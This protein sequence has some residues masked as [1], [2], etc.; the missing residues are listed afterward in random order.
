MYF[1]ER[2]GA[3]QLIRTTYDKDKKRPK[4][5]ILG[6]M[7]RRKLAVPDDVAAQL[8]PE[9][10]IELTSYVE[11]M[12]SLDVMRRKLEAHSLL[13][14]VTTAIEYARDLEDDAERD[15][16]RQEFAQA[17]IALRRASAAALKSSDDT[18]GEAEE[19]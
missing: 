14:T 13:R 6:R 17:I 18:A 15:L 11:R 5:E 16:L 10:K 19:S 4:Q 3:V 8:T 1:R 12:H 7:Q 9:E 2:G